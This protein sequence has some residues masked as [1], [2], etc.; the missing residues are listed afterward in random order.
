MAPEQPPPAATPPGPELLN[1]AAHAGKGPDRAA[2]SGE[3]QATNA[4]SG[5]PD[6]FISYA[7]QDA[8]LANDIVATLERK[9]LRCWIAPRDVTPGG[10]Y[11][12]AIIG[13]ISGTKALVLLLSD[14]ALASK[15]VG[16]EIERASSKG[17]A[18]IAL[19][20]TATPLTPAFEYFLSES[21][22]I[23][24]GPAGIAGI[25]AKLVEAVRSHLTPGTTSASAKPLAIDRKVAP[26]QRR[27]VAIAS[28]AV[29][30][31]AL[32]Y[33]VAPKFWPTKHPSAEQPSLA[34][35]PTAAI[36]DKSIA[37]LPF[38]DMSEKHDQE[39]FGDGMAEEIL[40][41]LAK[42]P[43]LTVIGR[44]SS[45]SFKGK[46]EDLRTI[47]TQL[48]A[49]YVVE[50]SVR[51]S[52]DKVRITAQ[53][54]NTRTGAH[55]W[56]ETYDRPIGDVLKLQD[57]IAGA[58]ARELHLTVAPDDVNARYI[59]KNLEI[60]DL[61]LRGRHAI[62]RHDS[63]GLDEAATLFQKALDRD[64]GFADAAVWL[65]STKSLQAQVGFLPS[66]AAFEQARQAAATA[67]K[68]DPNNAGAHAAL[69]NIYIVYDW[70]WSAAERELQK[71]EALAPGSMDALYGQSK[72]SLT[73]G[74]WDDAL[75]KIKA[76]L[77]Q[78]PLDPNNLLRLLQLQARLG[79]LGEAETAT[80]RLL[81][82]HPTFAWAHYYLGLTLLARGDRDGALLAMQQETADQARQQ[83]LAIVYH[84]LGRKKDSDGALAEMLR[85]QSDSNAVG[86]ADVYALRGQFDEAMHWLDR[87]YIQKD[88]ELWFI[89]AECELKNLWTAPRYK[90]FLRKLNLP[91]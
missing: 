57:S 17:R 87:A 20:T 43:G 5:T 14:S 60:Y 10:H 86:I 83:G 80:R 42:L 23:D 26:S 72:L 74:H 55:E 24:I 59:P 45:F 40:N 15:H 16:K 27:W 21:Q 34:A 44:T 19:R 90:A 69:A 28:A 67:L 31:T 91:E 64:P 62:D 66:A 18:I 79:R 78:D 54:I 37:V 22:W 33:V 51:R 50:G 1:P 63:G 71:V 3:G 75:R 58:V 30:A 9:N 52:G 2:G 70:D 4:Q 85:D 76:L 49:A 61:Y 82:I 53:L 6:V 65:S 89:K 36:S 73:L 48:N 88:S 35:T 68:L 25:S 32:A 38:V 12:D 7:S 84:A 39:Y 13:A 56:S 11:A 8:A 41:V 77:A 47:G 29:L 46:S 81:D